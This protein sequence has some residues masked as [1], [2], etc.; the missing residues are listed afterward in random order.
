LVNSTIEDVSRQ[1]Q[2]GYETVVGVIDRHIRREVDWSEY[3]REAE[4]GAG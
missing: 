3:E 1:E 4:R 2:V